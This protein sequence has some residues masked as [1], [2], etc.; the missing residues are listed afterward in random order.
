M[1]VDNERNT[2]MKLKTIWLITI[3][4][5]SISCSRE[6]SRTNVVLLLIDTVNAEHLGCWGY[7]RN[8]SPHIDSLAAS[9]T[10]YANCQ[11][12]APWTLPG[13][14]TILTGLTE[15][16][17]G[18]SRYGGFS[19]GLDPE[20]PTLATILQESGYHTAMF[21]NNNYLG[22]DFGLSNG[23]DSFWMGTDSIDYADVTMDTV[24]SYMTS[25]DPDKPFLLT[26]H[27][28]DPHL[29]YDPPAPFDTVFKSTGTSGQIVWPS[30][31]F[32]SN[33]AVIDHM[34]SLYDSE[35]LW[36][37]S[38]LER[39]FAF[40]RDE[41][42][43]ENTIVILVAD[44]GEE[45]MEH[46]DWGHAHNLYQQ[47][48]HVPLIMTGP[49]IPSGYVEETNVGQ[50]DVLPTILDYLNIPAPDHIEGLS[51]LDSIP[52]G[53]VI[54]SSGVLADTSSAACLQNRNKVLWFVES[55]SVETFDLAADPGEMLILPVDSFLLGEVER[56]WAWPCI[57][58]PTDFESTEIEQRRLEDL[59]YIR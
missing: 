35:L 55:D 6:E 14:A 5:L 44:H 23:Y 17:H 26:V 34:T 3:F 32:C 43:S 27:L 4:L 25:L 57:C 20:V 42:L 28:F 47:A 52:V 56:Y 38:Q 10:R 49:G 45:F 13:M 11:A 51:L 9:G 1:A 31:E 7:S 18:C 22:P 36:T 15:K 16:S 24:L 33:Q 21:I 59:G 2:P 8:T 46:G 48:L 58:N 37:D 41:G 53:R 39:L 30:L 19:H 54:P 50:F 29:P 40:L 12:Q